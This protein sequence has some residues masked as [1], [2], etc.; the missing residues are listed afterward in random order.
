MRPRRPRKAA[1]PIHELTAAHS[2]RTVPRA[3]RCRPRRTRSALREDRGRSRRR[4]GT[5]RVRRRDRRRREARRGVRG[6]TRDRRSGRRAAWCRR[7]RAA[8]EAAVDELRARA[9]SRRLAPEREERLEVEPG[10]LSLRDSAA[11]PRERDRHRRCAATS[12]RSRRSAASVRAA[13]ASYAVVRRSSARS[14]SRSSGSASDAD[15]RVEQRAA[16]AVDAD[17][18]VAGVTDVSSATTSTAGSSR[19]FGE[20]EARCPCRRSSSG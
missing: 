14:S 15:L 3:A 11:R 16:H 1:S 19:Q 20:R 2:T 4:C 8:L 18:I 17:A 13:A 6:R 12:G 9:R 7:R 10:E 5:R